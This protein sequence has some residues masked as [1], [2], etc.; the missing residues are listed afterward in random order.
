MGSDDPAMDAEVIQLYAELLRRLGIQRYL[1][2]LN[3]IGDRECR[4]AY[5]EQLNAWL[6]R[7][8]RDL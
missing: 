1:L 2:E 8:P 5:V 4:P 7:A 6:G 3:S